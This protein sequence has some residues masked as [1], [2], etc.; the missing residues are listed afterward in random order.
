MKNLK[1]RASGSNLNGT[2]ELLSSA[3]TLSQVQSICAGVTLVMSRSV[4]TKHQRSKRQS[5][6]EGHIDRA[7]C[8]LRVAGQEVG[9]RDRLKMLMAFEAGMIWACKGNIKTALGHD[10]IV[11]FKKALGIDKAF[12]GHRFTK[13]D[14]DK[15]DC[16]PA[17]IGGAVK[18]VID[19]ASHN[20][21]PSPSVASD[22][23]GAVVLD[24]QA[25]GSE[26][27]R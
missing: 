16:L 23:A 10:S 7:L 9:V 5:Q 17:H 20:Q 2:N 1:S 14:A 18:S 27:L 21:M 15:L 24:K 12:F 6:L 13:D 25:S 4:G 26:R 19:H 8:D 3:A 22:R 11:A